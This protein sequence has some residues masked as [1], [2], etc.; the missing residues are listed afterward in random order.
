MEEEKF[1]GVTFTVT[2]TKTSQR[3]TDSGV[4]HL[5]VWRSFGT[6]PHTSPIEL[7]FLLVGNVRRCEGLAETVH[8]LHKKEVA[9]QP[10][11]PP[12]DYSHRS[13]MGSYCNGYT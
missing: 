9:Q 3:I 5:V 13:S 12:G 6:K 7:P 11:P 4:P 1:T 10:P 2:R 8:N